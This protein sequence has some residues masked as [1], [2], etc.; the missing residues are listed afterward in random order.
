VLQPVV[1]FHPLPFFEEYEEF[2]WR[3]RIDVRLGLNMPR[4]RLSSSGLP[5]PYVE[6]GWSEQEHK[7]P[8]GHELVRT[9]AVAHNNNPFWNQQ[10]LYKNPVGVI[11]AYGH[12]WLTIKDKTANDS[13]EVIKIPLSGLRA[14]TPVH[15][16]MLT[17]QTNRPERCTLYSSVCLETNTE[18]LVDIAILDVRVF[19]PYTSRVVLVMSS[20]GEVVHNIPWNQTDLSDREAINAVL[21]VVR[22]KHESI[23]V[24]PII[25][26]LAAPPQNP[27][28][29][30]AVI[31]IPRS[32]I[33]LD[34]RFFLICRGEKQPDLELF[35]NDCA[36]V[37]E[38][39]SEPLEDSLA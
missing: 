16:E 31:T 32:M 8:V 22:Q 26:T 20:H 2:D 35:G 10:L 15:F 9:V 21:P 1:E 24:T 4:H 37:S 23:F 34:L 5:S 25:D 17:S 14:F 39:L 28:S 11:T 3:L 13:V 30:K 38:F 27:Y 7:Q 12:L 29:A 36:A 33:A 19:P 18:A 6:I